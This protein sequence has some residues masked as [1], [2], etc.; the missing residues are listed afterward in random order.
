MISA[1]GRAEMDELM[2]AMKGE[3]LPPDANRFDIP[4]GREG[5]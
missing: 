1:L 5:D 4:A 3:S 2:L